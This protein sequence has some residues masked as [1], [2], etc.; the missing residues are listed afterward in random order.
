MRGLSVSLRV[1]ASSFKDLEKAATPE[2][3]YG[4][5]EKFSA[6]GIALRKTAG[7]GMIARNNDR[8]CN[9]S[10][11]LKPYLHNLVALPR[12]DKSEDFFEGGGANRVRIVEAMLTG[13]EFVHSAGSNFMRFFQDVCVPN[14]GV[15]ISDEDLAFAMM[16][17]SSS[18]VR[19]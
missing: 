6:F 16:L 19:N 7:A 14:F 1:L 12:T 2:D 10:K 4:E 18:I 17:V 3:L 5:E 15:H 8:R 9:T 13:Q 11:N